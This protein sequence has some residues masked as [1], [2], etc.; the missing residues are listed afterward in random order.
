MQTVLGTIVA[1]EG[2]EDKGRVG[3]FL[4]KIVRENLK[5]AYWPIAF[6]NFCE[7]STTSVK[8]I[9]VTSCTVQL[10]TQCP[11]KV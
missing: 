3:V 6:L 5:Q 11:A 8:G 7:I 9:A 4:A 1:S 10:T 2:R